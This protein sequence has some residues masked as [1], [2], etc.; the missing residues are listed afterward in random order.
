MGDLQSA[1][2]SAFD[3]AIGTPEPASTS[4]GGETHEPEARETTSEPSTGAEKAPEPAAVAPKPE[5]ETGDVLFDRLTPDQ[6]AHLKATPEGRALYKGL[7]QSYT[8]KMQRFSEQERLWNALNNP[9]TQK[10]AV[11]A[12]ARSVGLDIKPTDQ[13]QRAQA[14]AVADSISDEWSKVVGAEAATLLRPLIEKTALAAVQG[15]LQ[16]L[17]KASE[18]LQMDARSRQ[19]EAQV[20]QFRASCQKNGW[21]ITPQIEAKMAELGQQIMPAQAIENV[22]QGVK[23]LERLYR[24]ATADGAEAAIEKRI[25]ERMKTNQTATEPSRGVPSTGR[26]KRSN[27]TKDMGLME[28]MDVAFAEEGLSR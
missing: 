12:L 3:E 27:I 1:M 21:E 19:A 24:L 10:Q 26:E 16:P 6:I 23:H 4:S 28:A 9:E 2:N 20:S 7:M 11:E 14:A 13:P 18:Y 22:D 8:Q 17:Q 15:T 5:E 25:L